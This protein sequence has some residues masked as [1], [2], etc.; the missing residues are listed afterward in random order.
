MKQPI[1]HLVI[2]CLCVPAAC[3]AE[4]QQAVEAPHEEKCKFSREIGPASIGPVMLG[5]SL[6]SYTNEHSISQT[7]TRYT[8]E[9]A[10]RI[11][12]CDRTTSVIVEVDDDESITSIATVSSDFKTKRGAKIGMSLDQLS[13]VHPEGIISTGVEEGGWIAYRLEEFSGYFEFPVKDVELSCLRKPET[14]NPGFF[15]TPSIS[16]QTLW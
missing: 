12:F 11:T 6:S 9:P 1:L 7:T 10:Y 5:S 3:A 13:E 4:K 16:Y 15:N 14:C 8:N 2:C